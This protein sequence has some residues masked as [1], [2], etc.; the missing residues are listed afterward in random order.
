MQPDVQSDFT[1]RMLGLDGPAGPCGPAGPAGPAGPTGPTAPTS[2]FGPSGPA[3]PA[4]PASPCGPLPQP[5]RPPTIPISNTTVNAKCAARIFRFSQ[6]LLK[7]TP[8]HRPATE[9]QTEH[10]HASMMPEI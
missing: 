1:T 7:R 6:N 4:G 2:P 3:G 9:D 5:A 8:A 10:V